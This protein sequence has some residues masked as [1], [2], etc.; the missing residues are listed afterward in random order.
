MAKVA[1]R[2][3]QRKTE[4]IVR[5][6]SI[7][8]EDVKVLYGIAKDVD[9]HTTLGDLADR[10]P[11]AGL[12]SENTYDEAIERLIDEVNMHHEARAEDLGRTIECLTDDNDEWESKYKILEDERDAVTPVTIDMCRNTDYSYLEI[13]ARLTADNL[14]DQEIINDFM[15][16]LYE[17]HTPYP[18]NEVK[19]KAKQLFKKALETVPAEQLAATLDSLITF[20]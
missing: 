9:T 5:T 7:A 11:G 12:N 19:Q 16:D 17:Q 10:F 1:K 13:G 18:G 15:R 20:G 3:S 6:F 8:L 2:R 14:K 4:K